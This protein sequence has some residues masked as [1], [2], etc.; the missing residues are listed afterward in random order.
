MIHLCNEPG[1]YNSLPP[2]LKKGY[3]RKQR[4]LE[5]SAC[6]EKGVRRVQAARRKIAA[7]PQ[8][9][10]LHSARLRKFNAGKRLLKVSWPNG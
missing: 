2:D 8:E 3:R 1:Q 10:L 5:A 4:G 9:Y 6:R 7:D